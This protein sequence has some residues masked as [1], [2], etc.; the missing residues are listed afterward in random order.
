MESSTEILY[1]VSIILTVIVSTSLIF[2]YGRSHSLKDTSTLEYQNQIHH[3]QTTIQQSQAM[4]QEHQTTIQRLQYQLKQKDT[5]S[6][7]VGQNSAKGGVAEFLGYLG[8]AI[9][10]KFDVLCMM[11]STSKKPSVDAIGF[12]DDMITFIEIKKSGATLTSKE[13]KIKK[14]VAEGKV[15][16]KIVDVN[17]PDNLIE[18]RKVNDKEVNLCHI[19]N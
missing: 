3:L 8:L 17:L 9:T 4:I 19:Q 18:V 6:W 13:N 14:L 12:N 16:Y 5:R 11:A 1:I 10:Q 2:F 15:D 7:L